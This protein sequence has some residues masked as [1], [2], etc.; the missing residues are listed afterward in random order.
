MTQQT[1]TRRKFLKGLGLAGAALALAPRGLAKTR[2]AGEK[3]N[4]IVIFIDD[5]GYG[6]IGPFGSKANRTPQLDKM[7]AEGMRFTSFYVTS[8]VCTPS[9]SSLMTGCYPRRVDLHVN[10]RNLCVLFPGEPKGLNPNETTVAEVL[11]GQGY[12]T[13]CIGKWHL[14]D[15]P[16]FLPTRQGFDS[17]FGIPYSND[18]GGR[19][20]KRGGRPPLPLM[21]DEKVIEAPVSQ[22][23]LTKR[24]TEEAVKFITANKDRPF[25]IYLPHAMVHL[26]LHASKAFKGKSG[27]GIHGDAVE[28][29]DWSTGRI[30]KALKDLGLDDNTLII[31]TSDNGSNGRHGGSNVPLRGNK[32]TTW[33]GGMRVPCLMRWPGKIPAGKTCG[34]MASTIDVLPTLAKLAGAAVPKD[35]TIDGRDIWPLMSGARGARSP[36]EA[37]YFYQMDQLQAVRSGKWKLF[38]PMESKKRNW[39]K[40]EGAKP[41]ML[42]DLE[43]DLKESTD[44]AAKHPDVVKRLTALADKA[45]AE[46]GDVGRKGTGQRKAGWVETPT[47]RLLKK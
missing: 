10:H 3:P 27:N 22:P 8:G 37:F 12:A 14:G 24:Y 15:Q 31:F 40:P 25:F 20:T 11:K 16:K 46:L 38:V 9:R 17:Y 47:P 30:I 35:R 4:F 1:H 19:S 5:M 33:E 6:D 29:L 28:E 34:E 23:T 45:R 21:R 36:H 2:P 44:V 7:A 39:G 26:P 32:G 43:A 13:T 41:V 18:M 42:F